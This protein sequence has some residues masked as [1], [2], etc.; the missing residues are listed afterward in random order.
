MG[1]LGGQEPLFV[2]L[3]L[4]ELLFQGSLLPLDSGFSS[5]FS[6]A[7]AV[8]LP[9]SN[10]PSFLS[11]SAHQPLLDPLGTFVRLPHQLVCVCVCKGSLSSL[12]LWYP[13]ILFYH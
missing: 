5:T 4:S 1:G 11:L 8:V 3:S 9:F 2:C 10:F 6:T 7:P 12:S 13:P